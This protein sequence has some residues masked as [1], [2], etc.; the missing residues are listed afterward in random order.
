MICSGLEGICSELAA[1]KLSL[2]R[3]TM[4]VVYFNPGRLRSHSA[5]PLPS[6][7]CALGKGGPFL[8]VCREA[9]QGPAV[10]RRRGPA[11]GARAPVPQSSA[12]PPARQNGGSRHPRDWALAPPPKGRGPGEA[13]APAPVGNHVEAVLW[14]SKGKI[15]VAAFYCPGSNLLDTCNF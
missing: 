10:T 6:Q 11:H 9:P 7:P 1:L 5:A 3:Q 14:E 15:G 13:R 8:G 4:R 2:Q 12:P